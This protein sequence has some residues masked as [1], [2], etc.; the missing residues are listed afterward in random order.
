M[1]DIEAIELRFHEPQEFLF[2]HPTT[3]VIRIHQVQ[4]VVNL[5]FAR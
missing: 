3:V 2:R 1:V 5:C 4:Q